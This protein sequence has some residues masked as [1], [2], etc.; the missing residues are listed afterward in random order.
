MNYDS[1]N[2]DSEAPRWMTCHPA[3]TMELLT[4]R[5]LLQQSR[6]TKEVFRTTEALQG[7]GSVPF[8]DASFQVPPG[9]P[10]SYL[11][12]MA[13]GLLAGTPFEN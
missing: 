12:V 3:S 5:P 6:F 2:M 1:E 4:Y 9:T 13:P 8:P 7:L 10:T 11:D